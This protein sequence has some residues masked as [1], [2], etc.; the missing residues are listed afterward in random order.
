[1]VTYNLGWALLSLDK[2]NHGIRQMRKCIKLDPRYAPWAKWNIACGLKML[3]KLP[4]ALS[5]LEEIS[6]GPWWKSISSDDWFVESQP[7]DFTKK[8]Q[9]LCLNK[10]G[11]SGAQKSSE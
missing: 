4:E 6:P 7:T 2:Y 8:F 11:L 5:V 9:A 1:L 10:L 3:E